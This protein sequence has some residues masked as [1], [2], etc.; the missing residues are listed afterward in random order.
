MCSSSSITRLRWENSFNFLRPTMSTQLRNSPRCKRHHNADVACVVGEIKALSLLY[1]ASSLSLL[2]GT[3]RHSPL[4][5]KR[6]ESCCAVVIEKQTLCRLVEE[7]KV[8]IIRARSVDCV[9]STAST[10]SMIS[11]YSPCSEHFCCQLGMQSHVCRLLTLHV[12][13]N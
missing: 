9:T 6:G 2:V 10:C 12:T 11:T 4:D 8:C 5:D 3:R 13:P 7:R 1:L